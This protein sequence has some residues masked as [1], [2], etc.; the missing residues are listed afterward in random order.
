MNVV[1]RGGCDVLMT[2]EPELKSQSGHL[3]NLTNL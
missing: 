1:S 3:V 2:V